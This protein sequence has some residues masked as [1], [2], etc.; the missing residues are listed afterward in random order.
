MKNSAALKT[1]A[2]SN[3]ELNIFGPSPGRRCG[4]SGVDFDPCRSVGQDMSKVSDIGNHTSEP[5]TALFVK[6]WTHKKPYLSRACL[7]S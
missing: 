4:A 2:F 1:K 7:A 3:T 5:K 6:Q